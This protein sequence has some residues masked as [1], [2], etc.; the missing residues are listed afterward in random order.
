M[1]QKRFGLFELL[2]LFFFYSFILL[3]FHWFGAMF[4]KMSCENGWH[5][6]NRTISK[7][8]FA[9]SFCRFNAIFFTHSH[10][11]SLFFYHLFSFFIYDIFQFPFTESQCLV[12]VMSFILMLKLL[13]VFPF[14]YWWTVWKVINEPVNSIWFPRLLFFFTNAHFMRW[15]NRKKWAYQII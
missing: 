7:F 12:L 6:K 10:S 5:N 1:Q 13:K 3:F 15:H 2:L 8:A 4:Q 9:N 11:L 14:F